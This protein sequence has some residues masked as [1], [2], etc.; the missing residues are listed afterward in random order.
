MSAGTAMLATMATA[1]LASPAAAASASTQTASAVAKARP[2]VSVGTPKASPS[3]YK[4]DC[5]VKV[6]FSSTVKVKAV[7][8]KTTVAYRWLRGDGSKSKVKTLVLKGKGVKKVTVKESSTFK[9]DVK[10]WQALQVLAPRTA[11][12][13]KGNF[14]VSCGG[15]NDNGGKEVIQVGVGARAWV[16][17]GNCQATL[18][19]RITASSPTWVRYRWVVNGDVVDRDVVRVSSSAKVFHVIRPRHNLSGWAA[20]EIVDPGHSTSNRV[21]FRIWC[22][23]ESPKV[24]ASVSAPDSYTGTCPVTRAFTGTIAV[25]HGQGSVKYRWIRD[26]VAGSWQDVYFG[27]RGY[28]SRTVTDSWSASAS[29]TAKRAIELY[30][31]STTGTV[32]GKVTCEAPAPEVKVWVVGE[33]VSASQTAGTC[34]A[35]TLSGTGQIYASGATKVNYRWTVDGVTVDSGP[36]VFTEAGTKTVT[37]TKATN[38][39]HGGSAKLAIDGAGA[40]SVNFNAVCAA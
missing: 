34:P 21:G 6:T 1:L 15:G 31:G 25:S 29:G 39:T 5:P 11:T 33:S 35:A 20:L 4:G 26:G 7:A 9:G 19:G 12:S 16:D 24:T 36:L 8:S 30:R 40:Q 13:S 18:V 37:F 2:A 28:Q 23:D 10:G 38:G 3:N 17:E 14:R 22:K 32:T 27:G